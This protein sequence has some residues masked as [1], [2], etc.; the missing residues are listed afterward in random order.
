MR[1]SKKILTIIIFSFI[2]LTV[3]I[4]GVIIF[5]KKNYSSTT[6]ITPV[7]S[8]TPFLP[9]AVAEVEIVFK[10]VDDF[11]YQIIASSEKY[12]VVGFDF[13]VESENLVDLKDLTV[14]SLLPSFSLY[15]TK[16]ENFLIL[17]GVKKLNF[18]EPT[19]FNNTPLV[20]L[21]TTK[22]IKIN[23]KNAWGKYTTKMVDN[24][25]NILKPK[26]VLK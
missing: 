14:S 11:T 5:R 10:K 9:Q 18:N 24:Q 17:T 2:F 4:L 22:A 3:F 13:I 19:V 15:S 8:P 6:K 12:D 20:E 16:K 7:I 21:K 1:E 23:L 25:N 26:I